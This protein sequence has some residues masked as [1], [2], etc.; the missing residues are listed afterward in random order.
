V[1]SVRVV[2]CRASWEEGETRAVWLS[3]EEDETRAVWLGREEDETRAVW[4]GR[5]EGR[6]KKKLFFLYMLCPCHIPLPF[7]LKSLAS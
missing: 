7:K 2:L 4:L 6:D 1:F 3:R 5:E